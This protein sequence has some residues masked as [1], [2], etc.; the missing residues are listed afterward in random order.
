MVVNRKVLLVCDDA[1]LGALCAYALRARSLVVT[2]AGTPSEALACWAEDSADLVI[3]DQ[4]SP[5]LNAV[6]LCHRLRDESINPI[7]VLLPAGDEAAVLRAYEA[8]ADECA[9]KPLGPRLFLAKVNALLRRSWTVQTEALETVEAA[10]LRLDPSRREAAT[11]DGRSMRLT[12]LEFRL[13]HVLMTHPRQTLDPAQL[14]E[15]VWGYGEGDSVLLK[16]VVYRLRRKIE[17][18]PA[19]PRRIV[20]RPG[21]GYSFL[22]E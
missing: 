20:T 10:G 7:L 21:G 8:G 11:A 14:V 16:N 3:I 1:E 9:V 4:T 5:R 15:R 13:L 2:V 18:D 12:N 6:D 17:A 22:P 19:H